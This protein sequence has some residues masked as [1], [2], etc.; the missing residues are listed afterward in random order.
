MSDEPKYQPSEALIAEV[1][2]YAQEPANIKNE[3][4]GLIVIEKGRD[5][6]KACKNIAE[7]PHLHFIMDPDDY[8]KIYDMRGIEVVAVTHSHPQSN[9]APSISDLT[10]CEN[11]GLPWLI[12]NPL[13]SE[14]TFFYPTGYVAPLIG[15]PFCYGVHDCYSLVQDYY[16]TVHGI[17]LN[18]YIREENWWTKNQD[19]Y[20][21]SFEK[22]GFF[23]IDR[24]DLR[25]GDAL[26]MMLGSTTVNHAAVMVEDNIILHHPMNR[27]SGKEVYG[28]YWHKITAKY[29]RHKDL[30]Q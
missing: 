11:S 12:V 2:K 25:V 20:L 18:D 23:E 28:G 14:H 16:L 13:T 22:E 4:C 21:D 5:H 27:L 3:I 24:E 29:L 15:R 6:F 30:A 17:V 9:T 26:L 19:M 8:A 10:A 1:L 7:E